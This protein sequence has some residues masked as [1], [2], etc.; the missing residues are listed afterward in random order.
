VEIRLVRP[1]E[2]AAVGSVTVAAYEPF[3]LGPDDP[4]ADRLRDVAQRAAHADV[5]VAVDGDAVLGTVTEPPPGSPYRELAGPDESEFRMLAVAP[6]AQGR[7]VGDA[8]VRHVLDR[9]RA[10]GR[11]A[12]R[13]SSLP[14]MSP[15]HRVYDRL[16][17]VR[18]PALDWEPVPGV[19][20]IA[21]LL[22]LQEPT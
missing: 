13:I 16:G 17:F 8:L 22:D 21:F 12:V 10:E 15:A 9:A 14:D 20:L 7:G 11:R 4:Y 2:H 19:A 18:T 1:E 6:E 3:L 5:W